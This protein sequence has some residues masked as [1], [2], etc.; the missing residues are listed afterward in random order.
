MIG[1]TLKVA[2]LMSLGAL[3]ASPDSHAVPFSYGAANVPE[4]TPAFPEQTR[5]PVV[6][7]D[8]A[9]DVTIVADG[10]NRPWGI[11][12]LPGGG[13]LVTERPGRLRHVAADGTVSAPLRG[14]PEVHAK[15]QGGLLDVTLSPD[16][17]RDRMV[18]LTY[19][20]P[21][22][23]ERS[24]TAAARG[25]L[26]ADMGRLENVTDIFVQTPASITPMHYGSRVLFDRAGDVYVTTGEHSSRRERVFAQD[27]D[28]TYGK[29][30]RLRPDGAIPP[31]N[32]FAGQSGA[33]AEIWSLGHRNIQGAALRPGTGQLWAI[34]HGPRGGDE[35][36]L[37]APG[38][39]YGWPVVSYGENYNG[40]PVGSGEAAH[41][42][43]GFVEP[44][45]YWDPVIAPGGM[46]F[47]DGDAFPDWRGDLFIGG[48]VAGGLVRLELKGDT[49]VAEERMLRDFGRVRDV[50]VA[51]DGALVMITDQTDGAIVRIAPKP[52][53]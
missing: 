50:T 47:Y 21:L 19:A 43:R 5:A 16:F 34:E 35:L 32:P 6:V 15:R 1:R 46:V 51:P 26:S 49:V 41:A 44:R 42:P 18:Y 25:R 31:D 39:N 48:L 10:L 38:S 37:I 17:A 11:A 29:I 2:A 27:L 22:G 14:V 24:V 53:G 40:S 30:V 4:F 23:G 20:K 12:A 3:P 13:Y 36:N 8:V 45:Y 33:R 9:L 7:S 28:K 52:A